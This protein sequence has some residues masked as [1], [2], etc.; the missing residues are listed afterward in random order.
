[1]SNDGE[2]PTN[3]A[4]Y[5]Y[6]RD[7]G[8]VAVD[9]LYL[10]LADYLGAKGPELVHPDWL[11]HAR[12]VSHIMN[13]GTR[14]PVAVD[15]V[16]L[17]NGHDLISRFQLRPGPNIGALLDA[18]EEARAS[19]EI[20][21]QEQALELAADILTKQGHNRPPFSLANKDIRDDSRTIS[22]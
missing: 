16:R 22:G 5:R 2:W 19:G 14:E 1:M 7:T 17:V 3:R 10:A 20:E 8:D 4:I 21:T 11:E 15:T 13:T 9:T 18:I 12:M 6:F